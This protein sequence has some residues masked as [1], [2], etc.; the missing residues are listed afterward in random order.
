MNKAQLDRL[1]LDR[2]Q[3]AKRA[4]AAYLVIMQGMTAYA[5]EK[6]VYGRPTSTIGRFVKELRA[7][8]ERCIE[9]SGIGVCK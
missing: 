9:I 4:E 3:N 8:F 5:A 7:D 6:K 2:P 1:L